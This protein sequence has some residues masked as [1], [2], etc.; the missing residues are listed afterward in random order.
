MILK[1]QTVSTHLGEISLLSSG[2]ASSA[3]T[4]LVLLH[5]MLATKEFWEHLIPHLPAHWQILAP[6]LWSVARFTDNGPELDFQHLAEVLEALRLAMAL[7]PIHLMAQDLGCLVLLR[8]V[9]VYP[10]S[11][12]RLIWLSPSLY[13]DLKLPGGLLWWRRPLIG[14]LMSRLFL[15]A[16]LR[17]YYERGALQKQEVKAMC[18]QAFSTFQALA[19]RPAFRRWLHWGQPSSLFWEHPQML[20]YI[21]QPSLILYGDSNPYVHYSQVERLGRH[22]EE[23]QVIILPD[24]GH[25]PSL[26]QRERIIREVPYFLDTD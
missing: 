13:P 9:H 19:T 12:Q 23:S 18:H 25:F 17:R 26:D 5:G 20:R 11:V 16:S 3:G 7:P 15:R 2:P 1:E 21:R 4:P 14:S 10:H 8:F 24:C 6:D 22:L